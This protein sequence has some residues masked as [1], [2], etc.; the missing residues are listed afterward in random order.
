MRMRVKQT[1]SII[2]A[3]VLISGCFAGMGI[4][5]RAG[6]FEIGI[7]S[8]ELE[9][10]AGKV[11]VTVAGGEL[12]DTIWW[13]LEK[14]NPAQEEDEETAEVREEIYETVG[15]KINTADVDD[16]HMK[17]EFS[18]DIPENTG[19]EDAV[20]R[21]RVAV[22]DPYDPETGEYEWGEE[23][24]KVTVAARGNE[25]PE[26]M[27]ET[28]LEDEPRDVQIKQETETIFGHHNTNRP[29]GTGPSHKRRHL[30]PTTP[31]PVRTI[32]EAVLLPAYCISPSAGS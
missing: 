27:N 30:R 23:E 28:V 17:S 1:L 2:L 24:A 12:G 7:S 9:S 6:I 11:T 15:E 29:Q 10:K 31:P 26:E 4:T 5:A 19:N 22:T 20:Y 32:P 21:I 25:P 8:E 18:V 14:E 3:F 16:I 13:V